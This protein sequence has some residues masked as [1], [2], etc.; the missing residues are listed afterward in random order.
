MPGASL[1]LHPLARCAWH[2]SRGKGKVTLVIDGEGFRCAGSLAR[3]LSQGCALT[4]D[5]V[6]ALDAEDRDQ[7]QAW[8]KRG[9][10]SLSR[11]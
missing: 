5:D 10:L 1:H 9:I 4:Q 3:S 6:A 8:I 11:S 7:V 2:P